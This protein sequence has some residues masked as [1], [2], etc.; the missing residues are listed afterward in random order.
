MNVD[1]ETEA[2]KLKETMIDPNIDLIVNWFNQYSH[3]LKFTLWG[4]EKNFGK[5]RKEKI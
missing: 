4:V 2:I 3:P 5:K 1:D